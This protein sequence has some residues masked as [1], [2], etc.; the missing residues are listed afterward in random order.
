[1]IGWMLQNFIVTA[2][3]AA[4]VWLAC[5]ILRPGPAMQHALWLVLLIKL[6][7]PPV[8]PSPWTVEDL[9]SRVGLNEIIIRN[10]VLAAP[11]EV[12]AREIGMNSNDAIA[13]R[14]ET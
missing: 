12:V 13:R 2:V 8:F 3:L 11:P 1:M 5:R 6:V 4:L 9:V 7:T 10:S 14:G